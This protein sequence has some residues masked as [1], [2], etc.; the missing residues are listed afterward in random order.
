MLAT[1]DDFGS[2]RRRA[3]PV[4]ARRNGNLHR[5]AGPPAGKRSDPDGPCRRRRLGL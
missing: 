2:F 1:R 3:R 4:R 5:G